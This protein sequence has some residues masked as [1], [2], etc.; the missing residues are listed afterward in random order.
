MTHDPDRYGEWLS[1]GTEGGGLVLLD[2]R[3]PGAFAY[4]LVSDDDDDVAAGTTLTRDEATRLRDALSARLD[5]R[6]TVVIPFDMLDHFVWALE[7]IVACETGD[8]GVSIDRANGWLDRARAI[9]D[10]ADARLHRA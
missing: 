5:G 10:D 3:A 9:R 7:S 8:D 1:M 4:L 2:G 6:E